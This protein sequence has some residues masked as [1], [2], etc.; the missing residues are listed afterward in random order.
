MGVDSLYFVYRDYT[1]VVEAAEVAGNIVG[2]CVHNC[3]KWEE[4]MPPYS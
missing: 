3:Y 2:N 1:E 4:L